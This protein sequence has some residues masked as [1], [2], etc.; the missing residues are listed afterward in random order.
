ME[1]SNNKTKIRA[2]ARVDARGESGAGQPA[3]QGPG[4]G[5]R[6]ATPGRGLEA[7]IWLLAF[8]PLVLCAV[9]WRSLPQQLPM[10]FSLDGEVNR[11]GS[12]RNFFCCALR[13]RR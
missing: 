2:H 6:P 12:N 5:K 3:P 11:L 7:A 13:A 10:Q 9:L 8:A 4:A 1:Q